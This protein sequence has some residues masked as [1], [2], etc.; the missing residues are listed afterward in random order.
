MTFSFGWAVADG[1]AP[2]LTCPDC[3]DA[4]QCTVDTC[5]TTTGFC[6]HDP[7]V[8]DDGNPC[9]TDSCDPRIGQGCRFVALPLG[10]PCNDGRVCTGSDH[11]ALNPLSQLVCLGI[12]LPVGTACDIG[13]GCVFAETCN[14]SGFCVGTELSPGAACDDQNPCT[15][16]DQCV[17]RQ[18]ADAN[19]DC[20]GTPM[21]CDDGNPCTLDACD[22]ALGTCVAPPRNCDDGNPCTQESC[23]LLTGGCVR[24]PIDG[25]CEDFHTF[26]TINDSCVN[27]NCVGQP[28]NCNDGIECT[29][30]FCTDGIP[31]T[32]QCNHGL[33]PC[34]PTGNPC[35]QSQCTLQFGGGCFVTNRPTGSSCTDN[36]SCTT[37]WCVRGQCTV[38]LGHPGQSCN[39]G[40]ICT[41]NDVCA[42]LQGNFCSGT[43]RCD[44]SNPCTSD[45]CD[46]STLACIFT[47]NTV[48]CSD[49]NPCTAGDTCSA[50]VCQPGTLLNCDD[51]I[52]CTADSC[53]GSGCSHQ[54]ANAA[55]DDGD[56]CT[57][58]SCNVSS[59]CA[60]SQINCN[61]GNPCTADFCNAASG[62]CGNAPIPGDPI[63]CG[64]GACR[65][66]VN[67]CAEGSPQN[68]VPGTPTDETCNGIDDDCDG[69]VD[70]TRVFS[71]CTV[72][73]ASINLSS[74]GGSFSM[75]CKLFD[76][77][78]PEAPT[79]IPGSTVSQVYISRIDSAQDP[80]DD[81]TLPDPATLP[82]PDPVLG[83]I[84]ERGISENLEARDLSN[85]NVTFKFNLP[86]DG[87]CST[88]D[89]D[90]HEIAAKLASIPD[91][92]S[93][94]ICISGKAGGADFQTCLLVLV[95]NKGFR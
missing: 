80:A 14:E 35:T 62:L 73:P 69:L 88:L 90:R 16:G 7:M 60:H 47:N 31:G 53:T 79:P 61:D 33:G 30:D 56:S 78:D 57:A 93:A 64:V 41:T 45:S 51:G 26:C 74:Q 84:Y 52:A 95:K 29:F 6:R 70:E 23:D 36:N 58:D 38:Q 81:V 86:A 12:Q 25:S 75:T 1:P 8:C 94:T 72:N 21:V 10:S 40:N 28:R 24:A 50:G 83:S 68:C 19:V 77:C 13:N 66:T 54:P 85:A 27:G 49:Q 17:R 5:D 65:R 3:T 2:E 32:G 91:N 20:E 11:C 89:G 34:P 39:D 15:S 82:C 46:L 92:T 44:D 18:T 42:G 37:E 67:T 43:P 48:P 4:D 71:D 9:T 63:S 55:C 87:S 76:V 22:P 59:G